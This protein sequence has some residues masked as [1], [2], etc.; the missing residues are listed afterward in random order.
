[1][2]DIYRPVVFPL[3]VVVMTVVVLYLRILCEQHYQCVYKYLAS[4]SL[5]CAL[6]GSLPKHSAGSKGRHV[7]SIPK[8]DTINE[9]LSEVGN[10]SRS[11]RK[12]AMCVV[13][14]I[15]FVYN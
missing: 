5:E 6:C 1:M 2:I 12:T 3:S 14:A 7:R 13:S 15:N 8:P 11:F 10:L 9:I 4:D